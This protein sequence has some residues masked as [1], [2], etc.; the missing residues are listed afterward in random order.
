M[1]ATTVG[2]IPG[3]SIQCPKS[4]SCRIGRAVRFRDPETQKDEEAA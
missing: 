4:V 1:V 3:K 2:S